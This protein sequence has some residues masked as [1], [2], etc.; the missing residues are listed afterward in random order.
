MNKYT[1]THTPPE[2][3]KERDIISIQYDAIIPSPVSLVWRASF[4]DI[5]SKGP[6]N[7]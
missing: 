1:H 7:D 4:N 6:S 3:G 5:S 2:D